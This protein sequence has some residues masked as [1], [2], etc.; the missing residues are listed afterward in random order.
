VPSAHSLQWAVP[1]RLSEVIVSLCVNTPDNF[2]SPSSVNPASIVFASE[3]MIIVGR[4]G[5][6]VGLSI[7]PPFFW[8]RRTQVKS[9]A[10]TGEL[11]L[12][13]LDRDHAG[14]GTEGGVGSLLLGGRR[15]DSRFDSFITQPTAWSVDKIPPSQV[16]E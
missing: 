5:G 15:E 12:N 6:S 9:G 7:P 4:N 3:K 11:F 14:W 8:W 16:R 2:S 10:A 1:D 13:C